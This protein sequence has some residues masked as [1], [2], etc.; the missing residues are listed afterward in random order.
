M[1]L[2]YSN[3]IDIFVP[4]MTLG[5]LLYLD[6]FKLPISLYF[7]GY[8]KRT[9]LLGILFS[10]GIYV[11]LLYSFSNSDFFY[12]K[13][14]SVVY[15]SSQIQHAKRIRFDDKILVVVAVGDALNRRYMDESI[16]TIKF[17][18]YPTA[19]TPTYKTLLPCTVKDVDFNQSLYQTLRLE[20]SYCLQNKSFD[21]EGYWDEDFVSYVMINIYQCD[22]ETSNGKCKSQ[23][24]INSFFRDPVFPK[25]LAAFYHD[26]QIDF[27]DYQNPI[28]TVY[29]TDFIAIDSNFRKK[30]QFYFKTTHLTTDDGIIFS[31]LNTQSNFMFHSK[32]TDFLSRTT[33]IDPYAQ[34][35]FFASKEEV[36]CTRR[37]QKLPEILGSLTGIAHLIMFICM[38]VSNTGTYISTLETISNQLYVF[39]DLKQKKIIENDR[40]QKQKMQFSNK[41]RLLGMIMEK[42]IFS[43]HVISLNTKDDI[44]SSRIMNFASDIQIEKKSITILPKPSLKS[45]FF[46]ELQSQKS[47][48]KKCFGEKGDNEIDS[49]KRLEPAKSKFG[50]KFTKKNGGDNINI[51][52]ET[53]KNRLQLSFFGYLEYIFRTILCLKKLPEHLII[54]KAENAFRKDLDIVN[55]ISKLHD[56]EKL[57]ILLLNEDQ[58]FLFNYL[59]KPLITFND[60]ELAINEEN[61]DQSHM[62]MSKLMGYRRSSKNMSEVAE[63]YN[64]VQEAKNSDKINK[65][66]IELFDQKVCCWKKNI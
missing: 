18:Y 37:Y 62:K 40:A 57:K 12:K 52:S 1:R 7:D 47:S 39:P 23:E 38:L 2:F 24:E 6:L 27:Y 45:N 64:R 9:S 29:K 33:L 34:F 31:S 44:Q 46:N 11:F 14:P 19:T 59:S 15:Q 41:K 22:N 49:T 30:T 63:S 3:H 54:S 8:T 61:L 60:S 56:F 4:F 35:L 48:E 21:L 58:L 36:R 32:E 55:I 65:K 20:G 26:A 51:P 42:P 66:L 53:K 10:L 43:P 16:F 5:L 50:L 28:K 13:S 17:K 25:Y